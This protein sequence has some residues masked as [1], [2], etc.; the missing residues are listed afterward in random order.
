M[1]LTRII[2]NGVKGQS[3]DE[4][5]TGAVVWHGP[6]G[7]GKT[8]RLLATQ[9]AL[10]GPM[11][12]IGSG[13]VTIEFDAPNVRMIE[14]SL[15]PHTLTF[16]PGGKLQIRAGQERIAEE[17]TG[18]VTAGSLRE[19]IG[20]TAADRIRFLEQLSGDECSLGLADARKLLGGNAVAGKILDEAA[21]RF[22]DV[23]FKEFLTKLAE[24]LTGEFS[25]ANANVRRCEKAR[26]KFVEIRTDAPIPEGT[27]RA[28]RDELAGIETQL[29]EANVRKGVALN[30]TGARLDAENLLRAKEEAAA[31]IERDIRDLE[32]IAKTKAPAMDSGA[33]EKLR[34]ADE[35][36]G[37]AYAAAD[38]RA[39]E[40]GQTA[41]ALSSTL[42]V[43]RRMLKAVRGGKCPT[44]GTAGKALESRVAEM[45]EEEKK[46][47]AESAA[48]DKASQEAIA[49]R[50]R[51]CQ[52]RT[53]AGKAL[54]DATYEMRRRF[55]AASEA[56]KAAK[57][58]AEA[59]P[60]KHTEL[61]TVQGEIRDAKARV[62]A[63]VAVDAGGALKEVERL[64][65]LRAQARTQL[66][67]LEAQKT[68]I[69]DAQRVE[70]DLRTAR[71]TLEA[72][73]LLQKA[74]GPKGLLG[75]VIAM[76]LAGLEVPAKAMVKAVDPSLT[77]AF[78]IED[79]HCD[80]G[81][82]RDSTWI[83]YDGLSAS[84]QAAV[85]AGLLVAFASASKAPWKV[86]ILD[87]LEHIVGER[88]TNLLATIGKMVEHG[89]IDNFLGAMATEEES[90]PE[91]P[92]I[93]MRLAG[94]PVEVEAPWN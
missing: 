75:E 72:V 22:G 40:A 6:N 78:R 63:A 66:Q 21:G 29:S 33:L 81:C 60:R 77:F 65:A 52:E 64:E 37:K 5:V 35:A 32:A 91:I 38:A 20:M 25:E 74:L 46:L 69:L 92:G 42:S 61:E 54:A 39:M 13:R 30:A 41:L 28:K 24:R 7:V 86:L 79:G 44:C 9:V 45:T 2:A 4:E 70:E 16:H 47:T 8:T 83:S 55:Q 50:D 53:A 34:E 3:F 48:A 80:F 89:E 49:A 23:G 58:A 88:R 15:S 19:F 87:D 11:D 90:F 76:N 59:L 57:Q 73:K 43:V 1:K 84:E 62:D 68:R 31:R 26:E 18:P 94:K 14:R 82:I 27:L 93:E 51:V 12:G 67:A 56:A 36:A 10:N 71:E 17:V 85:C